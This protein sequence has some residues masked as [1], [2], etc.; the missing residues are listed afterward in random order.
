M[1]RIMKKHNRGFTFIEL[2]LS[3]AV[4]GVVGVMTI[5]QYVDAA[6]HALDDAKW[7]KSVAVKNKF[8]EVALTRNKVPTVTVL[9]AYLP[10]ETVKALPEGIRLMVDGE[11]YT[12]PTYSNSTCTILTKNVEEKI[13]CV[14]SIL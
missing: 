13:L 11:A 6:Q 8:T 12:I 9:A 5:P 10:G 1:K 4:L 2:L 3:L 7:E 14:G